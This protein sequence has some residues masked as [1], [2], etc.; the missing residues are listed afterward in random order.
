MNYNTILRM[1]NL[2]TE[3]V[4]FVARLQVRLLL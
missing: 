2:S 3:A 1:E 4:F